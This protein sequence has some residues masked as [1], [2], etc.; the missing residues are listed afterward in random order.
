MEQG[1]PGAV[2]VRLVQEGGGAP[3]VTDDMVDHV[4]RR[5]MQR[6]SLDA[7][8]PF[9]SLVRDVVAGVS[10]RLVREEIDRIRTRA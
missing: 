7:S 1:E 9:G 3:V 5:V 2:P 4:A 10:E 6:L 8:E